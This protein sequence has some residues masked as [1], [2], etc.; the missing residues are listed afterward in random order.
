MEGSD[1]PK[2]RSTEELTAF[3]FDKGFPQPLL[4]RLFGHVPG[5][6]A[7][8]RRPED[9]TDFCFVR[10]RMRVVWR[11]AD[12]RADEEGRAADRTI[13]ASRARRDW[14]LLLELVLGYAQL[15]RIRHIGFDDPAILVAEWEYRALEAAAQRADAG[16]R[17]GLASLD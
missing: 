15:V 13:G 16:R 6:D 3:L 14:F 2:E 17:T 5:R 11:E 10:R 7:E 4:L 8:L 9:P 1:P 12:R